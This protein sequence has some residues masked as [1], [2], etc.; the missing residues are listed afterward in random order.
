MMKKIL[1]LGA[2]VLLLSGCRPQDIQINVHFD[3]L[4]GL[5]PGDRVLFENNT[6]GSVDN[7]HYSK[8]GTYEVRLRIDEGFTGAATE[9][10]HFKIVNDTAHSGHKAVAM[11]LSRPGGAALS[12]GARV[13]GDDDGDTLGDRLHQ[14]LEEGFAFFKERMEEFSED[15]KQVPDS[16]AFQQLK[17]SLSDLADD[18]G[19]TEKKARK[20]LK[21]EW[22]PRL[23]EELEE[24]ERQLRE[25]GREDEAAPLQEEINRIRKI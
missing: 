8:D 19:R 4:S 6:A 20:K 7:I 17:K 3:H 13:E 18:L 10:T 12:D 14:R 11:V 5:A 15:M 21:E 16:E 2:V 1:M 25:Y 9:H 23:E 24:L 22:L